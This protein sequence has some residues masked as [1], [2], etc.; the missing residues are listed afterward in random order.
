MNK[1][2]KVLYYNRGKREIG[3]IVKK[4]KRKEVLYFDILTERGIILQGIT[5]HF[6]F[7]VYIEKKLENKVFNNQ[8]SEFTLKHQEQD[9]LDSDYDLDI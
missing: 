3:S 1:N 9:I 5:T 6:S 8:L 2:D 4:I 7:P